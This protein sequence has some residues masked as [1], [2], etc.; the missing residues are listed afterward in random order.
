MCVC[1]DFRIEHNQSVSQSQEFTLSDRNDQDCEKLIPLRLHSIRSRVKP[2][3]QPASQSDGE[4]Y[5][6]LAVAGELGP[7]DVRDICST[8]MTSNRPTRAASG[9]S[10]LFVLVVEIL[11]THSSTDR[12]TDRQFRPTQKTPAAIL[13]SAASSSLSSSL[14]GV[15]ILI[16]SG[17]KLV[18]VPATFTYYRL[19][20]S[21]RCQRRRRRRR[22]LS[23]NEP[24]MSTS[25]GGA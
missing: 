21:S 25:N 16:G 5:F 3:S 17:W 19:I 14:F 2:A 4:I 23:S 6:K 18:C 13:V 11:D 10:G 7:L 8:Q 15:H 22:R 1:G 20:L 9:G 12:Q 24:S